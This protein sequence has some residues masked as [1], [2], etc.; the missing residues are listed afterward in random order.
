MSHA[1]GIFVFCVLPQSWLQ[2][3]LSHI[4]CILLQAYF[5]FSVGN[6]IP[7]FKA[8]FPE[9]WVT[10]KE[11]SAALLSSIHYSQ[12]L[13]SSRTTACVTVSCWALHEKGLTGHLSI[14][15]HSHELV[16]CETQRLLLKA[17]VFAKTWICQIP[18]R[19]CPNKVIHCSSIYCTLRPR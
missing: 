14:M 9:C 10:H 3:P 12:V 17:C 19:A 5:V 7:V 8:E 11:C 6:L 18:N 16:S 15:C 2:S 4:S 13:I 1:P